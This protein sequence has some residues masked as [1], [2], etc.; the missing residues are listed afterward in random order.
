MRPGTL[1]ARPR[2][3]V[4]TA[5]AVAETGTVPVLQGTPT[6]LENTSAP[7]LKDLPTESVFDQYVIYDRRRVLTASY[8][9]DNL[10][11]TDSSGF[12]FYLRLRR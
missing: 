7:S 4:E 11:A 5:A 10:A 8:A 9:S 3:V 6:I 12:T 2:S 1:A